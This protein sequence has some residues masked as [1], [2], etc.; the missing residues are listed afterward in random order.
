MPKNCLNIKV[1][2]DIVFEATARQTEYLLSEAK[3]PLFG[4]AMRGGK[5]YSLCAGALLQS[6]KYPGNRGY[7]ARKAFADFRKT[8]LVT[9]F[10]VIPAKLIKSHNKSDKIIELVNGSTIEY[11]DLEDWNKLR[12]LELGW[13]GIDEASEIDETTFNILATRVG[14]WKLPDGG[15]PEQ[16]IYLA[17]NPDAGFLYDKW[18]KAYEGLIKQNKDFVFYPAMPKDNPYITQEFIDNLYAILP[19]T[20]AK[21]YLDGSW[22]VVLEDNPVYGNDFN[23]DIHGKKGLKINPMLPIYRGWDFGLNPSCIFIQLNGGRIYILR[24]YTISNGV[25][26]LEKFVDNIVI[27]AVKEEV[28]YFK[29]Y[30][31]CDPSGFFQ[32]QLDMRSCV[33]VLNL[34]GIYPV[35]GELGQE[36]RRRSVSKYLNTMVDGEPC[37]FLDI[38]KCPVLFQGFLGRFKYA[39]HSTTK[40]A[41]KFEKTPESHIHEALQYICSGIDASGMG[42]I[43]DLE[44]LVKNR[45]SIFDSYLFPNTI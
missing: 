40:D 37:L 38:E 15:V 23:P 22:H 19:A 27:P 10:R 41:L 39:K 33:D 20:L 21:R 36:K 42:Q 44:D 14:W 26:G 18:V 43:V 24:E 16:K 30:D 25:M 1:G 12:S 35:A 9:L 3:Y 32:S 31:Y 5:S 4:G 28:P 6:L 34:R 13:A 2:D 17:S 7:L 8:T 45:P 29:F 11:G